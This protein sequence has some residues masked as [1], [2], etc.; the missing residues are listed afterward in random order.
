[1][2]VRRWSEREERSTKVLLGNYFILNAWLVVSSLWARF[3]FLYGYANISLK[4]YNSI[5]SSGDL[6]GYA[7][8]SKIHLLNYRVYEAMKSLSFIMSFLIQRHQTHEFVF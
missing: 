1:M 3:E 2:C 8:H 5:W 6:F 4:Y 7:I